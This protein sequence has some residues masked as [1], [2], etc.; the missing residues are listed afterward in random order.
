MERDHPHSYNQHDQGLRT[1]PD[2]LTGLQLLKAELW[3]LVQV[4]V[5]YEDMSMRRQYSMPGTIMLILKRR[6]TV[7]V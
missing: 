3:D 7:E 6:L 1:P 4:P 2:I 5:L